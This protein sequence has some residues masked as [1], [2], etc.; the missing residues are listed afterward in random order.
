MLPQS[1]TP[2]FTQTLSRESFLVSELLVSAWV[3]FE[4]L[5]V[6]ATGRGRP[7]LVDVGWRSSRSLH[8]LSLTSH[9]KDRND[10]RLV[11]HYCWWL[12]HLDRYLLQLYCLQ[13]L[14][15]VQCLCLQLCFSRHL[16]L[17]L[18]LHL[19]FLTYLLFLYLLQL[20]LLRLQIHLSPPHLM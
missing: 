5:V 12:D 14:L 9:L 1:E 6:V 20:V 7:W 13:I 11:N 4:Y 8:L 17:S 2:I 15:A 18:Y 16:Q 3:E 10:R 19:L